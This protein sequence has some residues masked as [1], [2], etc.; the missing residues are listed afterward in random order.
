MPP[1][2]IQTTTPRAACH[3]SRAIPI[4]RKAYTIAGWFLTG[5]A[6]LLLS[7]AMVWILTTV[8]VRGVGALSPAL[9][10]TTTQGIAGGLLNAIEGTAL[11]S[12][13]ALLL[14]S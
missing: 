8:F 14:L 1:D 10:T 7:S 2:Q 9:F 4:R 6:L 3:K 11:L 5:F 12:L 13:G